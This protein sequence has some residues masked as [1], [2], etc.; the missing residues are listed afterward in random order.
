MY[1]RD[2]NSTNSSIVHIAIVGI[3]EDT[4]ELSSIH[5]QLENAEI[6]CLKETLIIETT[7]FDV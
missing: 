3:F 2:F 1:G 4:V 5:S 7:T 6:K